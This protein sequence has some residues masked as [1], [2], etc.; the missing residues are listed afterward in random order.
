[1]GFPFGSRPVWGEPCLRL[2]D[3]VFLVNEVIADAV[4]LVNEVT[5]VGFF[6]QCADI[7]GEK[8]ASCASVGGGFCHVFASVWVALRASKAC[9]TVPFYDILVNNF[10][11]LFLA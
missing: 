4:F 11:H 3:A 8:T 7:V 2:I 5:R 1:M 10:L 9:L 6:N